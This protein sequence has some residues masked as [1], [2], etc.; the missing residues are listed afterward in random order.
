MVLKILLN[1]IPGFV[2][3]YHSNQHMYKSK[4]KHIEIPNMCDNN[5]HR[6]LSKPLASEI[7]TACTL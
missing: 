2:I 7:I 3:I 5:K 1:V 4:N 6:K